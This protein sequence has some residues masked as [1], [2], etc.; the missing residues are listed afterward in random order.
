MKLPI[1]IATLCFFS[2]LWLSPLRAEAAPTGGAVVAA[3]EGEAELSGSS[4]QET[5]QLQTGGVVKS[6]DAA[7]TGPKSKLL[8]NWDSG[9]TAS[10]GE[11]SSILLLPEDVNAPATNIQM[12]DG[13]LR[14]VWNR[15]GA[16][17]PQP[18]SVSTPVASIQPES[19]DQPVDFIVESYD[20]TSSVITV[21]NGRVKVTN[22]TVTPAQEQIVSSCQSISVAMGKANPD[23]I[24]LSPDDLGRLAGASTIAGT[25]PA[26]FDACSAFASTLPSPPP[27]AAVPPAPSPYPSMPDYYV[28][29]WDVEDMYPLPDIRVMPPRPGGEIAVII[30]GIGSLFVT[31]P[32]EGG[33]AFDPGVIQVYAGSVFLERTIYFDR[34]YLRDCRLRQRELNN[35]IYLAQ[36]TG[37]RRLL[38]EAQ[39]ELGYMNIRAHWASRR[40]G[41]IERRISSLQG[42]QRNLAGR[43][44]RGVN[45]HDAI[46]NSF[47]SPRNLP[48]LQRLQHRVKT[49][50]NVQNQL[51]NVAGQEMARLQGRVA[52]QRNPA[53]RLAMRSDLDKMRSD[54]ATG[55]LPLSSKQGQ[56]KNLVKQLSQERDVNK[57]QKLENHLLGQI[58][59]S[60]VQP[61][62][63]VLNPNSLDMLKGQL[64]KYPNASQRQDL[65]KR[66][67]GLEQSAALRQHEEANRQKIEAITSQAVKEK[68]TQKQKELLGQMNQ[69]LKSPAAVGAAGVGAAGL[70]PLHQRQNLERQIA[71]EKDKQKRESLQR[72]LEEIK[73]KQAE[74]QRKHQ[75]ELQKQTDLERQKQLQKQKLQQVKPQPQQLPQK[76]QQVKPQLQQ[77]PQNQLN[78]E[79]IHREQLPKQKPEQNQL[80]QQKLQQQQLDQERLRKQQL[81]QQRNREEQLRSKQL[82]QERL[83]KQQQEQE[84]LRR[85]QS[86]QEQLHRQQLQQQQLRQQ[87]L[88]QERLH[89]QQLQQ[90]QL[91][92]QQTQ[93]QQLRQQQLQQQQLRQQQ[94]HQQKPQGRPLPQQQPQP[95]QL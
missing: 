39:R 1:F 28:E 17:P 60:Q 13:I 10:L 88:Q 70:Q 34:Y 45:L 66:F 80:R 64:A 46:A 67:A 61:P 20:P 47:S 58:K 12:S 94:L 8:L 55:K 2:S 19:Y 71:G 75:P 35:L 26:S 83:R 62:P 91:R 53:V 56:I 5:G 54:L 69:L 42:E 11:Y 25:I 37:N 38:L 7:S 52:Q 32:F 23:L 40:I 68:N 44:P 15:P 73:T 29:D 59:K 31:I 92:Q 84:R 24:S 79:R 9:L 33:W 30:P 90:Q 76:L 65:Q 21:V 87:Q 22:L 63:N 36:V 50:L 72:S 93:Q 14:L 85:Q 43:L 74:S 51:A 18:Y 57:R 95:Q 82:E 48:V 86:Q 41:A 78:Q 89:Q 77:L 4:G 49:Q 6:D 16:S 3:I 81:N 27:T